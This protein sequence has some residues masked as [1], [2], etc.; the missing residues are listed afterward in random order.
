MSDRLSKIIICVTI[1]SLISTVQC[2]S[3][4]LVLDFEKAWKLALEKNESIASAND[5]VI[6][7]QHQ[8]G[9]AYAGAL[10]TVNFTGAFQHYFQVPSSIFHLPSEMN[11]DDGPLRIKTQFGSDNNVSLGL[12]LNQPLWIAG[13]VGMALEIAKRYEELSELGVTVSREDLR[14][15]LVQAFYAALLTE[16]YLGVSREAFSQG[17][18]LHKQTQALYDQG[19]V[20]EYDLIR[21]KVAVANL[22]PMVY[23]AEV[24]RD[25]AYKGLKNLIGIDVDLEIILEGDLSREVIPPDD[26]ESA[27][28]LALKDRL[29]FRQLDLQGELYKGQYRIEKRNVYWPNLLLNLKWESLAQSSNLKLTKYEFLVGWGGTLVLQVPL[30]DGWASNHRAEK[31]RVNLRGVQRQ[32]TLLERGVKVQVFQALSNYKKAGE[33]LTAAEENVKQAEKGLGIAEVRYREGVG[34]QLEVLD[35]QL[36]L[37][38]SRVNVLQA[39]YNQLV[40]RAAYDRAVGMN[41]TDNH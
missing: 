30:F 9:E 14:L 20:S 8:I 40:A 41:T 6:K 36:Q 13:K 24:G 31:A 3:D 28:N 15:S 21:A 22:K 33:D 26:Y 17:E 35:A 32:K 7:A 5:E 25:L 18:R 2:W 19:I 34:T 37:N 10:P 4:P 29:E 39:Q 23:Q 16:E 27:V 12:E 38:N 11:Q 1:I